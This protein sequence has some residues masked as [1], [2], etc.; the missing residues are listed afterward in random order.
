[1]K[2]C[3][4]VILKA[5]NKEFTVTVGAYS[6]DDEADAAVATWT[7]FVSLANGGAFEE[8]ALDDIYKSSHAFTHSV[9]LVLSLHD[10]GI[11]PI[12]EWS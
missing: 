5:Q 6:S 9:D 1:M 8:K 3:L 12:K 2:S 4:F 10:K 11:N 7:E